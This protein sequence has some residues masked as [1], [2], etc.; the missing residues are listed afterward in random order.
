MEGMQWTQAIADFAA[1]S[2]RYDM[3][4]KMRFFAD[5]LRSD[6]EGEQTAIQRGRA[7]LLTLLP[8]EFTR[9]QVRDVRVAQGMK[10]NP[11]NMLAQ[12]VSRGYIKL[13]STRG[14]YVKC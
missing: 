3:W 1:W 7:N 4:C 12:W 2:V 6:L 9:E 10:P 13:E 14:V 8:D 11:K 5:M